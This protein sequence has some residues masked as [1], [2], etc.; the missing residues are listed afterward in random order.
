ME[1]ADLGYLAILVATVGMIIFGAAI[2]AVVFLVWLGSILTAVFVIVWIISI[3][4]RRRNHSS[5]F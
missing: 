4:R 2:P 1:P 3:V 5:N